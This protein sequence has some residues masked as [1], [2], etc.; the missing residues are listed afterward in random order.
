MQMKRTR[1]H[2]T[3]PHQEFTYT[4]ILNAKL[5]ICNT[6]QSILLNREHLGK[7]RHLLL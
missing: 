4:E 3:Y 5:R 7:Y 6:M 2:V 1:E